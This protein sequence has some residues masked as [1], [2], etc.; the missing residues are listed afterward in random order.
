MSWRDDELPDELLR[1][2]ARRRLEDD[3]PPAR[4]VADE[5]PTFDV[6]ELRRKRKAVRRR[7]RRQQSAHFRERRAHFL[8]QGWA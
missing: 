4:A 3:A 5:H 1:A 6:R 2:A 8:E 7:G